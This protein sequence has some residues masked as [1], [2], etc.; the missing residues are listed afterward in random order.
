M[1]WRKAGSYCLIV[2]LLVL[3][4]SFLS[5][6][7]SSARCDAPNKII[8][9]KCCLDDNS[10]GVCDYDEKIEAKPAVAPIVTGAVAKD[11]QT[12]KLFTVRAYYGDENSSPIS[13]VYAGDSEAGEYYLWL[14]NTGDYDITCR[15][16]ANKPIPKSG[17]MIKQEKYHVRLAPREKNGKLYIYSGG[18]EDP[19]LLPDSVE[20]NAEGLFTTISVTPTIS[21]YSWRRYGSNADPLSK[22]DNSIRIN[23]REN[24]TILKFGTYHTFTALLNE[25][26]KSCVIND[27]PGNNNYSLTLYNTIKTNDY[28]ITLVEAGFNSCNIMVW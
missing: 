15:V 4:L 27:M 8:F 26:T 9:D 2:V 17:D 28:K 24:S 11:V 14:R 6:C 10:N 19:S 3:S 12:P 23:L 5:S 16:F 13:E 20:C 22:K 25:Q 21:K 1:K 18:V 7:T